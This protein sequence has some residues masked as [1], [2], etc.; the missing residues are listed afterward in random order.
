MTIGLRDL[1][2]KKVMDQAGK[3]VNQQL[4]TPGKIKALMD[5]NIRE[6]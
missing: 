1:D 5:T 3:T 2:I 4:L 6:C